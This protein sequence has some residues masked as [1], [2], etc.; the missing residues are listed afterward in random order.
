[1]LNKLQTAASQAP[2]YDEMRNMA[3]ARLAVAQTKLDVSLAAGKETLVIVTQKVHNKLDGSLVEGK[4]I[5]APYR[6]AAS[7]KVEVAKQSLKQN[8]DKALDPIPELQK[9]RDMYDKLYNI[10]KQRDKHVAAIGVIT[11]VGLMALWGLGTAVDL[12]G[13]ILKAVASLPL[14]IT[15]ALFPIA[16]F[17]TCSALIITGGL[18]AARYASCKILDLQISLKSSL[19]PEIKP[20]CAH[21]E[22][23]PAPKAELSTTAVPEVTVGTERTAPSPSSDWTQVASIDE[24]PSATPDVTSSE[25]KEGFQPPRLT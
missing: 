19:H 25:P 1:M 16:T 5:L 8:L 3:A 20:D 24:Q 13:S 6:E 7:A 15:N 22:E 14:G 21:T 11:L 18:R 4:H 10:D 2:S 23:V 17:L 12:T 9:Q